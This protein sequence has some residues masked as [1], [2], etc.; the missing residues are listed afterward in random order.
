MVC[1]T[2][3]VVCDGEGEVFDTEAIGITTLLGNEQQ[4]WCKKTKT[5]KPSLEVARTALAAFP[6]VITNFFLLL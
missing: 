4:I 3:A 2:L 1:K 5:R 6:P